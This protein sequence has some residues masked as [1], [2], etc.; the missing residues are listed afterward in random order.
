MPT[1]R[2]SV[3]QGREHVSDWLFPTAFSS[4]A[5]NDDGHEDRAYKRTYA[6]GRLTMGPEVA[7]FEEEIATYHGRRH[8][9][10]VNSGSS[11]NFVAV[12]ALRERGND[13]LNWVNVPAIAWSTTYSCWVMLGTDNLNILDVDDT[14]NAPLNRG[15]TVFN[16]VVACSILGNPAYLY[17]WHSWAIEK[18]VPLWE[19]N[20]ESLG[21]RTKD[22]RLCGTFGDLSTGSGFYSHQ[23]SAAEFGWILTDDDELARLCK[24]IRNHGNDGWGNIDFEKTYNFTCMGTNVRPQ[25]VNA[26][27][28]REQLKKL[29]EFVIERRAN[30]TYFES[31][32]EDLPVI[33]QQKT[34]PFTSPFALTFTCESQE[35]RRRLVTAFNVNGIDARMPTGGSFLIHPYSRR[36]QNQLT[37]IAD[38]IHR[39]S[40]FIGNAP[41]PIP[42]KI[43][44]AV[45]VMKEML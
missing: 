30:V 15:R 29:D 44:L 24:L 33:F 9:I 10:A 35:A 22:G 40:L 32:C 8:A 26:A 7:A 11:A 16:V 34:S 12:A 18:G 42:E 19:D 21:A 3:L 1:T 28:A 25:E 37:P 2:T 14:W 27:V 17:D 4:W 5:P 13:D 38:Q 31:L 45:K 41:W 20:C 39:T 43:E 36:W 23:C 6:S